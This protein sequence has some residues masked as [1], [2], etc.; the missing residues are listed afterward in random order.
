VNESKDLLGQ[1]L[2]AG[3]DYAW[4]ILLAIWGGTLNYL[5]RVK[6]GKVESFSFAELIGEWAVSGF[7]G[8]MT[9]YFCIDMELSWH[10]TA[11]FTGVSGHL[12]GR[13]IFIFEQ[14]VKS[15]F[16]SP[17]KMRDAKLSDKEDNDV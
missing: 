11:F 15:H 12:G 8:L 13:A 2:E 17:D 3:F 16:P 4:F 1:I 6:L 9:A 7:A 5:S 14:Y 10:M